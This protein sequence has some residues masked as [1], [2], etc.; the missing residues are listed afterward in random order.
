LAR[1]QT[2]GDDRPD[3][4]RRDIEIAGQSVHADP[5]RFH[6][7]IEENLPGMDRI[8]HVQVMLGM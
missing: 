4:V 2:A 1:A 6:K 3:S 5:E 8:D 7:N